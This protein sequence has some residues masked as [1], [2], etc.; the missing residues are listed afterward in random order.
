MQNAEYLPSQPEHWVGI[1]TSL[2]LSHL[3]P[4]KPPENF[5][6][7]ISIDISNISGLRFQYEL[8][9]VPSI[10]QLYW[11]RVGGLAWQSLESA[12]RLDL[13]DQKKDFWA[14]EHG[15]LSWH[16]RQGTANAGSQYR[17]PHPPQDQPEKK[18][19]IMFFASKSKLLFHL[20]CHLPSHTLLQWL[21]RVHKPGYARVHSCPEELHDTS[22]MSSIWYCM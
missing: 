3:S 21:A 12:I 11:A 8:A 5:Q 10:L 16:C 2:G 19:E 20:L 15:N 6:W 14:P 22:S 4:W 13:E 17:T 7:N 1:N 9:D 18:G